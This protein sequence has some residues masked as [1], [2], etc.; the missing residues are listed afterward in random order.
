MDKLGTGGIAGF[1]I[2]IIITMM[3]GVGV[4]VYIDIPSIVVVIGGTAANIIASYELVVLKNIFKAAKAAFSELKTEENINL[5]QKIIFYA[6]EIKKKGKM[7]IEP[8]VEKE[9]DPFTKEAF[10]LIVDGT[11]P[12]T[13]EY[14]LETK[15]EHMETR[16]AKMIQIFDQIASVA[17]TMGMVGTLIGLVAM[18][19]NLADPSA[20]GPAMAVALLTTLYGTLL[21]AGFA[22][23]I[24]NRLAV[25]SQLE[26]DGMSIITQGVL[27]I[28]QDEP[29]GEIKIKLNAILSDR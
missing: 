13:I 7:A 26:V 27:L 16:H 5:I 24:G 17:G 19:A 22:G 21:G 23:P 8:M 20:V 6:T 10:S 29:I 11:K 12:E 4:M 1:W 25:N 14:L 2:L 18:L 9:R 3:L 15:I 28:A